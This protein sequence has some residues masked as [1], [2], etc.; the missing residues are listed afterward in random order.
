MIE[1]DKSYKFLNHENYLCADKLTK[2]VR[3]FGSIVNIGINQQNFRVGRASRG[4]HFLRNIFVLL[5][6]YTGC[7][8]FICSYAVPLI[9]NISEGSYFLFDLHCKNSRGITGGPYGFFHFSYVC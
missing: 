3:I 6:N 7:I 2:Q 5:N 4:E 1:G 9:R 8:L